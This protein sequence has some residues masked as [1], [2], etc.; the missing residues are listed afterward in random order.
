MI[1]WVTTSHSCEFIT[2]EI[3]EQWVWNNISLK[4]TASNKHK[5]YIYG[6][7]SESVY[8]LLCQHKHMNIYRDLPERAH[9]RPS[10]AWN[11]SSQRLVPGRQMIICIASWGYVLPVLTYR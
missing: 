10:P 5:V 11:I 1:M 6:Q 8:Y 4:K 7:S 9:N 2:T 3:V